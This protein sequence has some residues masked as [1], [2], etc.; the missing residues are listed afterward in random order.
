MRFDFVLLILAYVLSQFFRSFL[1]VLTNVL[2][3]DIGADPADL[4]LAAGMWFLIFAAM[5]IPVAWALPIMNHA[6]SCW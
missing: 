5:Q 6:F 1:P 3:R 4:S 2:D